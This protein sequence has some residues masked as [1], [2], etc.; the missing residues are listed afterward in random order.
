MIKRFCVALAFLALLS[1]TSSAAVQGIGIYVKSGALV[2]PSTGF[3]FTNTSFA[4]LGN[5]GIKWDGGGATAITNLTGWLN[6]GYD[7]GGWGFTAGSPDPTHTPG[8]YGISSVTA[9]KN[10]PRY[11]LGIM[12]GATYSALP[13]FTGTPVHTPKFF[14]ETVQPTD[15]LVMYTRM[16]DAN[17]DGKVSLD[18][19]SRIDAEYA[20][21]ANQTVPSATWYNGDFNHDGK[22]NL[23]DYSL[24]DAAYASDAGVLLPSFQRAYDITVVAGGAAAVPEPSILLSVLIGI[25][26]AF[27]FWM[28]RK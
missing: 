23:D 6:T 24:L 5:Q 9:Y 14:G 19:Y 3:T 8:K 26:C 12:D 22:V 21:F 28:K 16:G 13:Y 18:D 1:A 25:G 4:D 17:F 27:A 2:D 10:R 7:T 11:A 15:A 20:N